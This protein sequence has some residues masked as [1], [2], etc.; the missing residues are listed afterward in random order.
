MANRK[1]RFTIEEQDYIDQ[2]Y[3]EQDPKDIAQHMQRDIVS[4]RNYIRR[5]KLDDVDTNPKHLLDSNLV[6][7][8]KTST[9]YERVK[10]QL[11]QEELGYFSDRWVDTMKQFEM[12]IKPTEEIQLKQLLLLEIYIDRIKIRQKEDND[13]IKRLEK[14]IQAELEIPMEVRD[15]KKIELIN[16]EINFLRGNMKDS[17]RS[18]KDLLSEFKHIQMQLKAARSQRMDKIDEG[19][20]SWAEFIKMLDEEEFRRIA[21]NDSEALKLAKDNA[22][23][24]L[25]SFHNYVDGNADIPILN[26]DS[27]EMTEEENDEIHR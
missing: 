5:N 17:I 1:G 18:Y 22:K 20:K 10:K 19:S 16:N 7:K 23:K 11:S 6:R 8:L 13:T 14:Q 26:S 4:V 21:G 12:N 27:I 9:I 2:N 3:P 24:G 25:Y 15:Y